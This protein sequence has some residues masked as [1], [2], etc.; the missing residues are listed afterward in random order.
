VALLKGYGPLVQTG[1][2]I[3]LLSEVQPAGKRPQSGVDFVNG[4]RLAEGDTFQ[5]G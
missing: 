2:G 3:L 1:S 5:A 4:S